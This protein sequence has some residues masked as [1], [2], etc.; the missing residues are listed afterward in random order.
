MDGWPTYVN[1]QPAVG[2]AAG[3][4]LGLPDP[5][6][7]RGGQRLAG[8]P[9]HHRPRPRPA[10]PSA[11]PNK[12]FFCPSRRPPA[13]RDRSATPSYLG[14][15][16]ATRALC[17]YAASNLEG[18]GVVREHN[19][20]RIADITDGTSNTLLVG[21]E[22]AEPEPTWASRRTT[23]TTATPPAGTPT[24]SG[25]RTS[26]RPRTTTLRRQRAQAASARPTPAGST[27]SSPTARSARSPTRSTRPSSRT[28]ATG[29][30]ARSSTATTSS[31]PRPASPVAA[32]GL[33]TAACDPAGRTRAAWRG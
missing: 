10:S 7:R 25:T 15:M 20:T 29:A 31:R 33:P 23:T 21:R 27:P 24:P 30:T 16:P 14:G 22:A 18:T 3:G 9:G 26:R 17:D 5:P 8:R 28:S 12:V 32:G 13:D 1:G 11:R 4:R 19:P 6:V 2:P